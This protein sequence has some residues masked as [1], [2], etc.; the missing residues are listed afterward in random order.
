M[1]ELR[2]PYQFASIFKIV[3]TNPVIYAERILLPAELGCLFK[4]AEGAREVQSSGLQKAPAWFNLVFSMIPRLSS[5][6]PQSC[7]VGDPIQAIVLFHIV[8]LLQ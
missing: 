8:T 1:I 3:N 2:V 7:L 5:H 6:L 4:L